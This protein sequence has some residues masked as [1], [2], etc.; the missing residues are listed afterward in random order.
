MLHPKGSGAMFP[1][2]QRLPFTFRSS[3]CARL[4]GTL[5]LKADGGII[6][7]FRRIVKGG[8]RLEPYSPMISYVSS[9]PFAV[10]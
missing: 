6:V 5:P 4:R 3:L 1:P 9:M 7:T 10:S 2:A 8:A